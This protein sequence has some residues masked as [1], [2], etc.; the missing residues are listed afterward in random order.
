[1]TGA[2]VFGSGDVGWLPSGR[3]TFQNTTGTQFDPVVP[4]YGD[5]NTFR[6]PNYHRLDLGMVIRFWHKWGESDLTISVYNAYDRRN[7]YILY[8]EPEYKTV[9]QGGVN[10]QIPTRIAAKQIS[11]FPILPSLTWNFKF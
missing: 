10:I 8:L 6:L 7:T 5:R 1:L 9:N 4:V 11:L 2:F 3:M